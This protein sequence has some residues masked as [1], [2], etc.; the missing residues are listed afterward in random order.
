[1]APRAIYGKWKREKRRERAELERRLP[2]IHAAVLDVYVSTL[3][4]LT[5]W[6]SEKV[7]AAQDEGQG[8][9]EG[10]GKK[11]GFRAG[12]PG[13]EAAPHLPRLESLHLGRLELA[14]ARRLRSERRD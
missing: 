12:T 14:R 9:S 4:L 3:Y 2:Q 5:G 8:P 11:H 13:E 6:L 7:Q 10:L 1:M